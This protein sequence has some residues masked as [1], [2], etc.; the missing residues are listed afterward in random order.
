LVW[1]VK[2]NKVDWGAVPLPSGQHSVTEAFV[3]GYAISSSTEHPDACWAWIAWLSEQAPYRQMP[4][5]RSLA[6][7]P[8]WEKQ[9][10][11]EV[12]TAARLSIE[13]AVIHNVPALIQFEEALDAYNT[14]L[15]DILQGYATP[16]EAMTR[17]Q[18]AMR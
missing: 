4:A 5:R 18:Q 9:V 14:V 6:E 11:T 8:D 10:G 7:S 15:E 16:L 17:A 3:E 12:A 2:L 1:P 13:H